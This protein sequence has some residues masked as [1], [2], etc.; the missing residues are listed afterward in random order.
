MDSNSPCR[1][2]LFAHGSNLAQKPLYLVGTV[3]NKMFFVLVLC[4]KDVAGVCKL[5]TGKW[6]TGWGSLKGRACFMKSS[7]TLQNVL[8]SARAFEPLG[9]VSVPLSA[10]SE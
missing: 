8:F 7:K 10:P 6:Y 9:A 4:F 1:D 2:L 5:D 3:L